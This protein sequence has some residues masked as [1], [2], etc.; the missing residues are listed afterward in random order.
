MI[1]MDCI[2]LRIRESPR[3]VIFYVGNVSARCRSSQHIHECKRCV[4][5]LCLIINKEQCISMSASDGAE[6][7]EALTKRVTF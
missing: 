1:V 2:A 4:L 5:L 3:A 7:L 6:P